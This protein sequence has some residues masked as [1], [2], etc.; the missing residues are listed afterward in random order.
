MIAEGFLEWFITLTQYRQVA[1]VQEN[2]IPLA[3]LIKSN[4]NPLINESI[5]KICSGCS[6]YT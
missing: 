6:T 5:H 3:R 4:Q 2:P 1:L